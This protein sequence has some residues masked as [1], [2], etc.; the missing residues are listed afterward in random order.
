MYDISFVI[1]AYNAEKTIKKCVESINDSNLNCEI[2]IVNDGSL[3]DTEKIIEEIRILHKNVKLI[4]QINSGPNVA[5][6]NGIKECSGKYIIFADSDDYFDSNVLSKAWNRLNNEDIDISEYTYSC[7]NGNV[8]QK[9]DIRNKKVFDDNVLIHFFRSKYSN[10]FL[11]NK[12]FKRE[13][14]DNV[15]FPKLFAGEDSCV[16]VQLFSKAK[17]YISYNE[18][19]YYYVNNENGLCN[20]PV[21]LK[22]LDE[23]KAD[24]FKLDFIKNNNKFFIS[25]VAVAACGHIS[26]TFDKIYYSSIDK[27]DNYLKEL[28]DDFKYFKKFY[29]IFS[30]SF[31]ACSFYR[32]C[33][34][35]IFCFS[36]IFHA[37]MHK[38]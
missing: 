37:K 20:S 4:N 17:S 26:I 7:V 16:L 36:P 33:S 1:P 2:I 3:D 31:L 28:I 9:I 19:I 34:I 21:S 32:K 35:M 23:I 13:L 15:E 22:S 8:I 27:K 6:Y 12:I 38:I 18:G 5:R 25:D 10:N 29:S 30:K 11:W 14:F 24:Y